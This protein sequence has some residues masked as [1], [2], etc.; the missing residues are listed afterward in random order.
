MRAA[1][2]WEF[3]VAARPRWRAR[4]RTGRLRQSTRLNDGSRRIPQ[5]DGCVEI[6]LFRS[7]RRNPALTRRVRAQ[8]HVDG[9][10]DVFVDF[11]LA[12]LFAATELHARVTLAL[13]QAE[14]LH[15]GAV[16]VG[17]LEFAHGNLF[18]QERL[19][20]LLRAARAGFPEQLP[21][22]R[23]LLRIGDDRAM[24]GQ[25]FVAR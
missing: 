15:R 25:G 11:A 1:G 24:H 3:A 12:E 13:E 10:I 16:R 21:E 17:D 14:E 5:Q 4:R 9:G 18:A 2:D 23:R 6:L 19:E 22:L 8:E 20:R 7:L